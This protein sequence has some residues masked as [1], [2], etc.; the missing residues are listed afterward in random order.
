[1][2]TF[3]WLDEGCTKDPL[4]SPLGGLSAQIYRYVIWTW[5][6]QKARE[7]GIALPPEVRDNQG[8]HIPLTLCQWDMQ[9]NRTCHTSSL[10]HAE[11]KQSQDYCCNLEGRIKFTS[12]KESMQM[13]TKVTTGECNRNQNQNIENLDISFILLRVL[14]G[15]PCLA[16]GS[17]GRKYY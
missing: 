8:S 13:T 1:M 15:H 11:A 12:S 9:T 7:G 5:T 14:R 3:S 6:V 17:P 4:E 2:S 16:L 10:C